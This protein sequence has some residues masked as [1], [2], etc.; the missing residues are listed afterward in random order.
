MSQPQ[1]RRGQGGATG[2]GREEGN[3]ASH[4]SGLSG[5]HPHDRLIALGDRDRHPCVIDDK[6]GAQQAQLPCQG[7]LRV[8]LNL[9]PKLSVQQWSRDEG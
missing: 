5:F 3:R 2:L 9:E 7:F 1:G 4:L 8:S 6:T